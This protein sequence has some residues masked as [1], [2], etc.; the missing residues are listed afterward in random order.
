MPTMPT[1]VKCF[2]LFCFRWLAAEW[3]AKHG[4][5][6]GKDKENAAVP[7]FSKLP[8]IQVQVP[9]Q[10]N[11]CDCGVFLLHFAGKFSFGD[12]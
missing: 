3:K 4:K 2:R 10:A 5:S 8:R 9:E 1:I 12:M 7:D 11:S 6:K